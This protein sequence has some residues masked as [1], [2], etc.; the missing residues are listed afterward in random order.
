MILGRQ[1]KQQIQMEI[2]KA[3]IDKAIPLLAAMVVVPAIQWNLEHTALQKNGDNSWELVRLSTMEVVDVSTYGYD[4]NKVS[5][6]P[7]IMSEAHRTADIMLDVSK[8]TADA[9]ASVIEST[10]KTANSTNEFLTGGINFLG[11]LGGAAA[12]VLP[13]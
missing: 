3:I 12:G 13:I 4:R 1:E 7:P 8:R 5:L 2:I 10:A 11:K 9:A 6:A